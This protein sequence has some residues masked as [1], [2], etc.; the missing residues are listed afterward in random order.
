[1]SVQ[2]PPPYENLPPAYHEIANEFKALPQDATFEDA[3]PILEKIEKM[4]AHDSEA[5]KLT[6]DYSKLPELPEVE[7]KELEKELA[8]FLST[9]VGAGLIKEAAQRSG[10]QVKAINEKLDELYG[11]LFA[12]DSKYKENFA[13]PFYVFIENYR[14]IVSDSQKLA[15]QIAAY[16]KNYHKIVKVV[17][18]DPAMTPDKKMEYLNKFIARAETF[19]TQ[20]GNIQLGLSLLVTKFGG[21]VAVFK[22]W[23]NKSMKDLAKQ[24]VAA[25]TELAKLSAEAARLR[26]QSQDAVNRGVGASVCMG[27]ICIFCPVALPFVLVGCGLAMAAGVAHAC[28]AAS[29]ASDVEKLRDGKKKEVEALQAQV[30]EYNNARADLSNLAEQDL[31]LFKSGID[32]LSDVWRGAKKDASDVLEALQ[33]GHDTGGESPIGVKLALDGANLTYMVMASYL[34]EYALGLTAVG[35]K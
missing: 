7:R 5:L 1:M 23:S 21:F 13:A 27:A 30:T 20:S 26:R 18:T 11:K 17:V 31:L 4:A 2:P 29:A 12:I 9:K 33:S 35:V 25:E 8:A 32:I 19:Q 14:R 24:L 34:E 3:K 10:A 6:D 28:I 16:G 22:E 15:A